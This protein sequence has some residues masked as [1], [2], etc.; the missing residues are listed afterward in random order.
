[1][2]EVQ[3]KVKRQIELL[4]MALNNTAALKDVDFAEVFGRDIPTI[5][6]DMQELRGLGVNIHS[7]KKKGVCVT[8]SVDTGLLRE[9]ITQ[10]T[11]ICNSASGIDKATALL[12]TRHKDMS[13]TRIVTIQRC[14][15]QNTVMIVDYEKENKQVEKDR[16]LC[17]LLIFNSDSQWRLLALNDGKIKQYLINKIVA[18]TVGSKTFKKVRQHII[19]DMFR[20]SFRSWV[21]SEQHHIR[22]LLSKV[23]ADRL[24]NRQLMETEVITEN[25]DG[26][27]IFE[28]T[29]N[30]LE[31][32]AS[33]VVSRGKGVKVLEPERLVHM[34]TETAKGALRNYR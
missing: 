1:M 6:R 21:G 29:V 20:Y 22:I 24:R 3:T 13:L 23:W 2:L 26:S 9:L 27:I 16:E 7:E 34:V 10:Y 18:L 32:V 15:E 11:G 19:A 4:G 8:G 17:P 25:K 12:V 5:K 33:W 28:A 14:I 30:S 31:E